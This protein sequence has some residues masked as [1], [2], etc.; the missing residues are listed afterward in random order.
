L[1][2][3]AYPGLKDTRR[4]DAS[5]V[6]SKLTGQE[7]LEGGAKMIMID[8]LW[9]CLR[10]EQSMMI[11]ATAKSSYNSSTVVTSFP[12]TSYARSDNDPPDLYNIADI[13]KDVL[14]K[15]EKRAPRGPMERLFEE[16]EFFKETGTTNNRP[17]LHGPEV[18]SFILSSA[19]LVTSSLRNSARKD[20]SLDFLELFQEAIANVTEKHNEFFEDFNESLQSQSVGPKVNNTSSR[21]R[22]LKEVQ[23]SMEIAD[24]I[25][26]L[27]MLK[28]LFETQKDALQKGH[29]RIAE[30]YCLKPLAE[31]MCLILKTIGDE[32]LPNVLSMT[33]EA[34]RIQRSILDLL[35]IEQKEASIHEAQ[36][37]NLQTESLNQHALFSAKQAQ[38]AQAQQTATELQSQIL[39]LF[40]LATVI[41]LP[42]SFMTSYYGMNIIESIEDGKTN[43][44][45]YPISY[46]RKTMGGV[47]AG[48]TGVFLVGAGIWYQRGRKRAMEEAAENLLK[49]E[50]QGLLPSGLVDDDEYAR[51][52]EYEEKTGKCEDGTV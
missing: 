44:K 48:I 51:M 8:Q 42:L 31:E 10:I 17:P 26:E 34:E 45:N 5:Q 30:V 2:Q 14:T 52:K 39:F 11:D 19:L 1:D 4:R 3:F 37:A 46:V 15:L 40:T 28:Q 18:A 35:D 38:A 49:L 7:K 12:H 9:L 33:R 6:V 41:F 43:A 22:K 32:Y 47:S 20:W 29:N 13:R 23:L 16:A 25:D 27:G 21:T 24:I 36:Y 50:K